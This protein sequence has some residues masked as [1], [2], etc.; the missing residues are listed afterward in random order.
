MSG[1]DVGWGQKVD[2]QKD[3]EA[4]CWFIDRDLPVGRYPFKFII[5]GRWT[6]SIDHPVF[7]VQ[8]LNANGPL[9]ILSPTPSLLAC[10]S[11]PALPASAMLAI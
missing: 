6:Y 10:S 4:G 3:L 8:L 2:L 5:N 7:L 1:L 11:I 9:V